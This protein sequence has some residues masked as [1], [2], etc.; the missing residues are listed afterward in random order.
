MFHEKNILFFLQ[1]WITE[2]PLLEKSKKQ[3]PL[4]PLYDKDCILFSS[5]YLSTFRIVTTVQST[6][7]RAN[8]QFDWPRKKI[9]TSKLKVQST[10]NLF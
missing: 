7:N 4:K 10:L 9:D 3:F 8:Y 1:L 2:F 5:E 6:N